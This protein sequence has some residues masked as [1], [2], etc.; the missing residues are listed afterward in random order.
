MGQHYAAVWVPYVLVAFAV[1]GAQILARADRKSV[2]W[3][4]TSAALCAIVTIFFS[5]LHLGCR[6]MA[7]LGSITKRPAR[8]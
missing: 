6:P 5:P 8:N 2:A 3:V 1:A 4:R 7:W